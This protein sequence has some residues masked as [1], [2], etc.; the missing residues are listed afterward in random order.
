[1]RLARLSGVLVGAALLVAA[2]E[3]Q[4]PSEAT[5]EAIA[6]TRLLM[7]GLAN[8]NFRGLE[9]GLAQKPTETQAWVFAR[10]QALLLAETGNLLM[11]RPPH[12]ALARPVWFQRASELRR[13]SV[14]LA[15]ALAKEDYQGSR[16]AFVELANSCNRCH[17]AFR[18]PT[19]IVPF[20]PPKPAPQKTTGDRGRGE[21]QDGGKELARAGE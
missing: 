5:M 13:R 10:G 20:A 19:E 11:L 6:E 14:E 17:R 2:A 3:G 16:T 15:Q 12:A 9:R 4:A 8:P 21:F 1:M 7:E 18:V